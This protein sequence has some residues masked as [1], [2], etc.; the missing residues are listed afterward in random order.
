MP[1]KLG[2]EARMVIKELEARGTSHVEVAR[3]L[4]V[5]EGAVRYHARRQREGAV[6][7]RSRQASAAEPLAEVI[8][9]Y[10]AAERRP[11][12]AALHDFLVAEHGFKGSL[13]AV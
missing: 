12:I 10:V 8:A 11:N 6:D 1:S 13:R 9:S 5:T 3:L 7:G 2:P 4:N